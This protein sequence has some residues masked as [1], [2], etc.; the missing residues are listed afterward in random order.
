MLRGNHIILRHLA[1]DDL[2]ALHRWIN[3]RD[4]VLFNAPYKPVSDLQHQRWFES[5]GGRTDLFVFGIRSLEGNKLIGSCQLLNISFIHR[6]A[7]LQIRLG[8]RAKQG[9]GYG[10]EA[11]KL[12]LD[13][14]FKD[15]NLNR[16]YLH[17]F[18]TNTRAIRSYEKIG[19]VREG[20]LRKAAH[21]DGTY[22]DIVVMGILR[23]EDGK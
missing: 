18:K 5:I 1:A 9:L 13:F 16:I 10:T 3:D 11:V 6:C 4:L 23:E 2:P 14:G 22:V 8:D 21:I 7:E 19:F 17:V 15:L 12:L 20:L